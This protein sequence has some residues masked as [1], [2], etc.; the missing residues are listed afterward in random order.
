M[1]VTCIDTPVTCLWSLFILPS[2]Y[3]VQT[4]L[5]TSGKMRDDHACGE[6]GFAMPWN[7]AVGDPGKLQQ[8]FCYFTSCLFTATSVVYLR[9]P[10]YFSIFILVSQL[11]LTVRY[12]LVH[13]IYLGSVYVV[14]LQLGTCTWKVA[15]YKHALSI[16]QIFIF[17]YLSDKHHNNNGYCIITYQP[18]PYTTFHVV[19]FGIEIIDIL[20]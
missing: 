8:Y 18:P 12:L 3:I 14:I 16:C 9:P 7:T 13:I 2:C 5:T 6:F 10:T 11:F 20:Q 1:P 4:Y 19:T 15:L 17:H